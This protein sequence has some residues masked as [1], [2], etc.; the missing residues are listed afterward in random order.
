MAEQ[1]YRRKRETAQRLG[2]STRTLE[3]WMA[4]G[5]V[6]FRKMGKVVLFRDDEVDRA[7]DLFRHGDTQATAENGGDRG[8]EEETFA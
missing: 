6:P 7:L 4:R 2:I 5:I 3:V 1:E 8:R